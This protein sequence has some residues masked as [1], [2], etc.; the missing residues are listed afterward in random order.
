MLFGPLKLALKIVGIFFGLISLYFV[1]TLVQ[2]WLTSHQYDP[3]PAGAIIVMG[4]A[5]YNG[6]PSP[7]LKARLDEALTLFDKGD[8][9][10]VMVTGGKRPGDVYTE[11]EAGAHYLEDHGVPAADVLEAGGDDSYENIADAAPQLIHRGVGSVL[12]ATDPFHEYRS[13]AI[14]SSFKLTPSPT[15]T[16][17]SPISGWATVPYFLKEAVGVSFGRIIGYNHLEWLHAA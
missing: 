14:I 11:A 13:M 8:A 16:H 5:Q 12:V 4:A 10:L 17:S 2:V 15:P 9:K 6:V 1:V 7:D 3:H